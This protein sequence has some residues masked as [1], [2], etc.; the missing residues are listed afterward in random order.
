VITD[1]F[2]SSKT[3][4]VAQED[5]AVSDLTTLKK[6][7]IQHDEI[8]IVYSDGSSIC[9]QA[10]PGIAAVILSLRCLSKYS[11]AQFS[12]R[13]AKRTTKYV[14]QYGRP[15]R[16]KNNGAGVATLDSPST[17]KRRFE[18][19]FDLFSAASFK[20]L[21][22]FLDSDVQRIRQK[23]D[24]NGTLT[25]AQLDQM[26][27]EQQ[28]RVCLQQERIRLAELGL[29][30]ATC[31]TDFDI[32]STSIGSSEVCCYLSY[33]PNAVGMIEHLL[34]IS[35]Y[36]FRQCRVPRLLFY[37][38]PLRPLTLFQVPLLIPPMSLLQSIQIS[39]M[40]S[41][42]IFFLRSRRDGILLTVLSFKFSRMIFCLILSLILMELEGKKQEWA[43]LVSKS[44]YGYYSTQRFAV[45]SW[46]RSV[47]S[48]WISVASGKRLN[49]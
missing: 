25:R 32:E 38:F 36:Y 31:T 27:L 24:P 28:E 2:D 17:K 43:R 20:R 21:K 44:G 30:Y 45:V 13:P 6:N 41:E 49:P 29:L 5:R 23:Y 19:D 42:L 34:T 22:S 37:R 33:L 4:M 14:S 18:D 46:R 10:T 9:Y 8:T 15:L 16:P 35:S 3:N 40:W 7:S 1:G 39:Y 48:D 47:D 11:G 26:I 12:V